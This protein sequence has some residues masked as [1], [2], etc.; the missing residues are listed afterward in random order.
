MDR[1]SLRQDRFGSASLLPS[2]R[3]S[4]VPLI[5]TS[6]QRES[7]SIIYPI[8]LRRLSSIVYPVP[9]VG[10]KSPL[11]QAVH[12]IVSDYSSLCKTHP[13]LSSII[14][15]CD[16]LWDSYCLQMYPHSPEGRPDCSLSLHTITEPQD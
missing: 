9:V 6:F 11:L 4:F 12:R 10:R 2:D 14:S 5:L 15:M 7:D 8:Y 1:K 16:P 13:R 3:L